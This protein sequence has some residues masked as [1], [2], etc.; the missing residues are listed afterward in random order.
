MVTLKFQL[1]YINSNSTDSLT[2][3]ASVDCGNTFPYLLYKKGGDAL[4]TSNNSPAIPSSPS[5]WRQET[6]NISQISNN[7]TIL[8]FEST[9]NV[10]SDIYIDNLYIYAGSNVYIPAIVSEAK[11]KVY[12]NPF[13]N[14]V[15]IEFEDINASN[16]LISVYD[17]I[18]KE[19]KQLAVN[20]QKEG[21]IS[22]DMQNFQ[23]GVYFVRFSNQSTNKF[24]KIIKK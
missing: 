11:I 15:N 12:P 6:I 16:I 13:N 5:E 17:I 10:G 18:G 2:I 3:F 21:N 14:I 4:A 23:S 20:N 7:K 24:F 1:S 9:N 22:I 19:I 8:K